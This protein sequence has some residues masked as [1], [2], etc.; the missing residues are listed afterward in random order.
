[1]QEDQILLGIREVAKKHLAVANADELVQLDTDL[2]EALK[3]DSLR[4]LTLVA[5]LE[6]RFK[7]ILEDGDEVGLKTVGD[8]VALLERRGA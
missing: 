6:N 2:Y 8:L 7:V 5:E 4:L 1:M 3:L